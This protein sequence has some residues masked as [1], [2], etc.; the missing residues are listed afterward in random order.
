MP[1]KWV[2]CPTRVSPLLKGLH[3]EVG[4]GELR[5]WLRMRHKEQ[6]RSG[7]YKGNVGDTLLI[8]LPLQWVLTDEQGLSYASISPGDSG[9]ITPCHM[10]P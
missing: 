4:E 7:L 6:V 2:P 9:R 1:Y 8:H 5:C 10:D 3:A